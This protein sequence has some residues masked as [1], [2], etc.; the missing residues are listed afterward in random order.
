MT[1][2]RHYTRLAWFAPPETVG[3]G[4]TMRFLAFRRAL[5]RSGLTRHPTRPVSLEV[6]STLTTAPELAQFDAVVVDCF[7]ESFLRRFPHYSKPVFALF[8]WLPE[9]MLRH[10]VAALPSNMVSVAIEP[11]VP[12]KTDY[13]VEPIVYSNPSEQTK[14]VTQGL[15]AVVHSSRVE[16]MRDLPIDWLTEAGLQVLYYAGDVAGATV[17]ICDTLSTFERIV[18]GAGYNR[19]WESRW[20]GLDERTKFYAL[21][22][23]RLVSDQHARLAEAGAH[24]MRANGADQLVQ[25]VVEAL[26]NPRWK[27]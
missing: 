23:P 9:H 6:V 27:P 7:A 15:G 5:T 21:D 24:R 4:H 11:I 12:V 19:Y 17:P 8:R 14:L 22:G 26:R 13:Q 1:I 10:V 20:L 25:L 16:M 3:L 2:R 18:S